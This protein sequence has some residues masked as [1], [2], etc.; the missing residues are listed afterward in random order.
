[1]PLKNVVFSSRRDAESQ[2]GAKDWAVIS[3]TEP[4]R[5]PAQ[6]KDGWHSILRLEFHDIE[7]E[8]WPQTLFSKQHACA[9]VAF[10]HKAN[11]GTCEGI[12]VHCR[13]GISRSSAVAKWIAEKFEL[14][15]DHNYQLC[16]H[17]VYCMLREFADAAA[18]P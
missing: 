17:R 1:M 12:L 11:A 4:F 7:N 2:Q 3:I 13:A 6:L 18:L 16:N 8:S 9:I 5:Y 14:P 15:F 10:A